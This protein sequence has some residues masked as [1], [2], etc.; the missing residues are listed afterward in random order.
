MGLI[1]FGTPGHTDEY[2]AYRNEEGNG[3][4]RLHGE[5]WL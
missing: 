5:I 1:F 3:D 2:D 4:G